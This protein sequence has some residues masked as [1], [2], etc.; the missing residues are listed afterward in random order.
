[1][2]PLNENYENEND[3]DCN[4]LDFIQFQMKKGIR[5]FHHM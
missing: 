2:D 4:V 3:N 1:M 5:Q